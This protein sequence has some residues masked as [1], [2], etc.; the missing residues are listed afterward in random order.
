MDLCIGAWLFKMGD[1]DTENYSK[2]S[3]DI[4]DQ[5]ASLLLNYIT[6]KELNNMLLSLLLTDRISGLKRQTR[7]T[8][9]ITSTVT[10]AELRPPLIPGK[11]CGVEESLQL[12]M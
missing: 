2:L 12:G 9:I 11:C 10:S 6:Q 3:K 8:F 5:T 7:S 1:N 4:N